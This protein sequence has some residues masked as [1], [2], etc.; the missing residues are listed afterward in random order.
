MAELRR[1]MVRDDWV[2]IV[3]NRALKPKD[4]PINRNGVHAEF[5][6]SL[7]PFCEGHEQETTPEIIA[8]RKEG[9]L[10][11]S[12]G[13]LVR[14][15]P[16][17]F[18]IFRLE[19]ELREDEQGIY[20]RY[21]NLGQHEVI[22]ETPEHDLQLHQLPLEQ[23][24]LVLKMMILRYNTLAADKRIKFIQIYKNKGLFAGAS[25][26][27][28]HSQMLGFPIIPES[29]RGIQEYY[30]RT[31]KCLLCTM[32][33]EERKQR[34]RVIF[35]SDYFLVLCPFASRFP[36]EAWIIPKR[37]Q[38]HFADLQAEEITNLAVLLKKY[39]AS[40]LAS[41]QDPSYNIMINSAPVNTTRQY[42]YHWFMEIN[43]RLL[44]ANGVEIASGLYLN[45]VA[46]EVAAGILHSELAKDY[47]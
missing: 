14:T 25:Q 22:I 41:L 18:P 1:D 39:L 47:D 37:H 42:E 10:P 40:M 31:G 5:D 2:V 16:N 11:D 33:E 3:T 35:E 4:F 20:R 44:V 6:S 43:P 27:H 9:S 28:S 45:P 12:P 34:E 23:V 19:G 21:N 29:Y 7:C 46:P 38:P 8:F 30:T 15:I 13:W 32:I 36:Y 24:E 26:G 17:K